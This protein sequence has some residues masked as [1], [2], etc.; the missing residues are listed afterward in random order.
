MLGDNES[1]VTSSTILHSVLNKR[2]NFLSYH[3]VRCAVAH[4]VMFYC[5][6]ASDENI[7]DVMTKPLGYKKFWPLVKP[8]LF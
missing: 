6:I 7:S 3:R 4:D 8:L 5:Y 1:V 2:H